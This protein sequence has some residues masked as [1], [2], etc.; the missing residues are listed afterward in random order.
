MG[1][2]HRLQS[3]R[4]WPAAAKPGHCGKP[5]NCHAGFAATTGARSV[6]ALVPV[7]TGKFTGIREKSP[8]TGPDLNTDGNFPHNFRIFSMT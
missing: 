1:R 7:K 8:N 6:A 5:P 3:G 2:A 4:P